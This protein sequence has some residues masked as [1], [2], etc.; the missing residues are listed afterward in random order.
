MSGTR[1]C[2][3]KKI[4]NVDVFKSLEDLGEIKFDSLIVAVAHSEFRTWNKE[5]WES[6]IIKNGIIYDL[7]NIVPKEIVSLRL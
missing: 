7:K 2:L 5:K 1:P 3:A 6:I 4:Y